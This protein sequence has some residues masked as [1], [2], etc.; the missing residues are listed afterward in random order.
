MRHQKK[1]NKLRSTASQRRAL[2]RQ[3]AA[4]LV[5]YDSIETTEAKAKALRP[6]AE[7]LVTSAADDSVARRRRAVISLANKRA[8]KKLFEVIGPKYKGRPGG[9]LRIRKTTPRPGDS[10]LQ[11]IISFV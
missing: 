2:L 11:A 7:K 9:Y 5:L 3:L 1:A 8:V 10:G 4:S 6:Y